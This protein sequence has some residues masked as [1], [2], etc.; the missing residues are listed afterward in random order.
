MREVIFDTETTGLDPQE[1]RIIELGAL[2]VED[3][4][5][6]GETFRM[7]INPRRPVSEA[8]I[9]VTGIKDEDLADAPF[10]E[11]PV[12]ID[13]FLEFIGDHKIVAH[14]AD[15]DRGFINA[16]LRRADYDIIEPHRFIDTLAI[17]RKKF[18]G[19]PASLDALCKRFDISIAH[20]DL[21]GALKDAELLAAVYLELK[22]GR[23]QK[24]DFSQKASSHESRNE[25]GRLPKR[26]E[27]LEPLIT[28]EELKAHEGFIKALGEDA[29][30]SKP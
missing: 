9:R 16:E 18:P 12:V 17:A 8:T 5:P 1:D 26:E 13:A 3:Y 10:F 15:F 30:W 6:T 20:R 4:I 25:K 27:P 19:S 22:G 29:V 23:A 28:P 11:D 14:N 7:L 2:I 21:H 24:L